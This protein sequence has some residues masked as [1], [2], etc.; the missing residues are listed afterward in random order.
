[1]ISYGTGTKR[2]LF[3]NYL[4]TCN[5][6]IVGFVALAQEIQVGLARAQNCRQNPAFNSLSLAYGEDLITISFIVVE[7]I[8]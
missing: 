6:C 8:D 5:P 7:K 3:H 4:P 1:M 2:K